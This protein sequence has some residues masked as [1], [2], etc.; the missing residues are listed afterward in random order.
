M[1]EGGESLTGLI[2]L[3]VKGLLGEQKGR[4]AVGSILGDASSGLPAHQLVK[5]VGTQLVELNRG[6]SQEL[7]ARLVGLL[8]GGRVARVEKDAEGKV[9]LVEDGLVEFAAPLLLVAGAA[10]GR[11]NIAPGVH[12]GAAGRTTDRGGRGGAAGASGTARKAVDAHV[13]A[14]AARVRGRGEVAA[15]VGIRAV[16]TGR[17]FRHGPVVSTY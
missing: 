4:R 13:A 7:I 1:A 6:E 17:I 14:G 10:V 9:V 8:L 5:D 11:T 15:T 16:A 3:G 12:V 2:S